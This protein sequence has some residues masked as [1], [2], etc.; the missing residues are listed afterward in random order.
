MTFLRRSG[1]HSGAPRPD[2]IL[3]DFNLP[4]KDGREVLVEIKS[5]PDLTVIPVIVF[6]TSEAAGDI[7]IAYQHHANSYVTKPVDYEGF[8]ESVRG[9]EEFWL[10]LV[11]LPG[12]A[13]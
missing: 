11:Q 7:L 3:L 8:L 13:A 10:S 1:E 12:S 5:D 2:L 6:T 9:I 4:K